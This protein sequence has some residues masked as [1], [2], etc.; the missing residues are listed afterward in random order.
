MKKPPL[1]KRIKALS[2]LT[3]QFTL[4]SGKTSSFYWDK[5]RFEGEP[6]VLSAVVGEMK[7]LLPPA[8]DKLA[9]L[10]LGGIPLVTGLSLKTGAPCLYVRKTAKQYG[11]CNLIEGGFEPGERIVVIEDVVTTAGQVCRSVRQMR[12]L[13]LDV[14]HVVCAIDRQQGGNENLA[15]IG[16]SL[17]PVFTMEELKQLAGDSAGRA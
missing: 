8:F 17:N 3:G 12:E 15:A 13:G 7:Q 2:Y 16:C 6:A 10:E 4:R 11:T 9:G 14:Q 5:Y 1:A